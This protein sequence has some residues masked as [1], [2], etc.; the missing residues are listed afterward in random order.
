M[1]LLAQSKEDMS[2]A[3]GN[4]PI[5]RR[6][7]TIR[8][9][10]GLHTRAASLVRETVLKHRSRVFLIKPENNGECLDGAPRADATSVIEMLSL[11]ALEGTPLV[12]EAEGED[13]DQVLDELVNL[14]NCKF[15][16]DDFA[17]ESEEANHV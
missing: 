3:S 4:S 14:V 7:V 16:E 10:A 13:A 12:L 2:L 17:P 8:N 5:K 15:W 1:A 6:K 9:R 11:C